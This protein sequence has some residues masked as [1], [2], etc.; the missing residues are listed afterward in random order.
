[1]NKYEGL[2]FF[3]FNHKSSPF[4]ATMQSFTAVA[5]LPTASH[6]EDILAA[7]LRNEVPTVLMDFGYS[8]VHPKDRYNKKIGR[9][10]A[11]AK[12]KDLTLTVKKI[13]VTPT[14]MYVLFEEMVEREFRIMLRMNTRT[15]HSTV[16]CYDLVGS[17]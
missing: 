9:E 8:K 14:H 17:Y 6:I 3:H 10:Q 1:M 16:I 7:F 11:F 12:M 2:K 15:R 5:S 4:N 13:E